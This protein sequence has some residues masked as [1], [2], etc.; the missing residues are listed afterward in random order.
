[1]LQSRLLGDWSEWNS[2]VMIWTRLQ[3][4]LTSRGP[5]VNTPRTGDGKS[6][7]DGQNGKQTSERTRETVE[8]NEEN[9]V[10][11]KEEE[12]VGA[13]SRDG[14]RGT[15]TSEGKRKRDEDDDDEEESGA[16]L[17]HNRT[18][19]VVAVPAVGVRELVIKDS[20]GD[21]YAR[22]ACDGT[23]KVARDCFA[24]ERVKNGIHFFLNCIRDSVF[25]GF[26]EFSTQIPVT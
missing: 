21:R 25:P 15:Q 26:H 18:Y 20:V 19:A 12:K 10:K 3:R 11:R 5:T 13:C 22:T 24:M 1:M 14:Q 2:A 23:D 9:I 8:E 16:V 4:E 7:G 6:S 17:E